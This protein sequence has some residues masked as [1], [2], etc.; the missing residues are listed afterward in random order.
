MNLGFTDEPWNFL[1]SYCF[2]VVLL[3]QIDA[4]RHRISL[5]MKNSYFGDGRDPQMVSNDG[6]DEDNVDETATV[7]NTL[8]PFQ[9]NNNLSSTSRTS[10]D[11]NGDSAI[12]AEAEMRTS[13]L[14]LQVSLDESE[15]SDLD[16]EANIE[17]VTMKSTDITDKKNDK[18]MKK[19]AKEQR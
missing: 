4:E 11:K 16:N 10:G 3:F 15:G 19:K 12:L 5:G 6:S 18:R 9:Q 1:L 14:P 17:P 8:F 7:D 2:L 13:V